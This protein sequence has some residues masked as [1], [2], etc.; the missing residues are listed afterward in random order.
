MPQHQDADSLITSVAGRIDDFLAKWA[1]NMA[2]AGYLQS[3]TAKTEDCILSFQWFLEPMMRSVR[4]RQPL[5]D[6]ASLLQ[7]ENGWAD[8]LLSTA[9]RHRF[10]GITAEM[11]VGC[12]KTLVHAV[13]EM[14]LEEQAPFAAQ[15][16][17][18]DLVR[19]VA[20]AGT[21]LIV[22][23]WYALSQ[24]EVSERCFASNRVLTLEKNKYENILSVISDLVFIVDSDG[25]VM[26]FNEAT[27]RYFAPS[28]LTAR[29]IWE[30]LGLQ[31]QS[32][33]EVLA[34]YPSEL[35]HELAARDESVFFECRVFPL[36]QV[37]L[38]SGGYLVVLKDITPHV[39]H[40]ATLEQR[41]QERTAAVEREK[42][43]L[44]EMN[45]TLRNVMRSVD[46]ELDEHR[47]A[48]DK[49]V[50]EVLLPALEN[51][52]R[53]DNATVRKGF[54]DLLGDQLLQLSTGGQ[55]GGNPLLLKLTP[56]EMKVCQFVQAGSSSKAIA[57][58]LNL[59]IGTVQTH[60]KNIRK[61][62]KLQNRDINLQTFLASAPQE[63]A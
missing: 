32:M 61:K 47:R 30:V 58:A 7:N 19:L 56:T 27:R 34:F 12:F 35:A 11:F 23:Q 33:Q 53:E 3:T 60:R 31:A 51:V 44:E 21:T 38:A 13:E 52:R 28:E 15:R 43:Q 48:I 49:A 62:L 4:D 14:I 26:E 16:Q 6:F 42:K 63:E 17:A 36:K 55:G 29:R 37:S 40:R 18:L 1:R 59:S 50:A 24:E 39:M 2:T 9:E 5:G 57:E 22:Q 54:V 20:D 25:G 41:V 8:P 45:I 10:R 46:R